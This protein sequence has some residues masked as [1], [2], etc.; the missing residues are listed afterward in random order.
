MAE[1]K[2]LNSN[3][4]LSALKPRSLATETVLLCWIAW[5]VLRCVVAPL[6]RFLADR[7]ISA[8][9]LR[10]SGD[11]PV[12]LLDSI[13]APAIAYG[14]CLAWAAW[15]PSRGS[16]PPHEPISGRIGDGF[17]RMFPRLT[18]RVIANQ[19][20][21][22]PAG[23]PLDAK[24]VAAVWLLWDVGPLLFLYALGRVAPD[25]SEEYGPFVMAVL[26]FCAVLFCVWRLPHVLRLSRLRPTLGDLAIGG[27]GGYLCYNI[28]ILIPDL[29]IPWTLSTGPI[30]NSRSHLELLFIC[31][32][33][34]V[35]AAEELISRG[36][37]LASLLKKM[38]SPWAVLIT[39]AAAAVL[40]LPPAR[41]SSVFVAWVILCGIYLARGRSLPAS[42]AAHAVT[43]AL[44]WFPGLVIAARLL[45]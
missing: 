9:I 27:L 45:R 17:V 32:V 13:L 23:A 3:P 40:H 28:E 39:S 2:T 14:L 22:G 42:F 12:R 24:R 10:A 21:A 41:W 20:G 44:G 4:L 19:V 33:F 37:I 8:A 26:L 6:F 5:F 34:V 31:H 15:H 11:A 38:S 25:V 43:N 29:P 36:V 18:D 35:P 7:D 1:T 16:V 30:G